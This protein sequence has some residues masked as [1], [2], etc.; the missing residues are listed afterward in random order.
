MIRQIYPGTSDEIRMSEASTDNR[1]VEYGTK[2]LEKAYHWIDRASFRRKALSLMI[3]AI[4]IY[5][6]GIAY[7]W[8]FTHAT[9]A[10]G[11]VSIFQARTQTIL[12]GEL[13]YKDVRTETPPLINYLMVPSQ[14]LG[15]ADHPWIYAA[16]ATVFVLL[17]SLMMYWWFRRYDDRKAYLV[18]LFVLLCP[19]LFSRTVVGDDDSIVAF[20]FMLG[21][22]SLL[23]E[24]PRAS[25]AAIVIGV[26]VKMW[27]ILLLPVQFLRLKSWRE[28]IETIAIGA[29]VSLLVIL[30]FL[31]LCYDEFVDFLSYYFLTKSNRTWEGFSIAHFLKQGG[32]VI[33]SELILGTVLVSLLA[34]ILYSHIKR[35]G[36]WKSATFIMIVFIVVY[37]KMHLGYY[38]MPMALLL[39]WAIDDW[40][41]LA[42]LFATYV[43]LSLASRCEPGMSGFLNDRFGN[44]WL[45]G[46][47][48]ASIGALMF[49]DVAR[50]AFKRR[51]FIDREGAMAEDRSERPAVAAEAD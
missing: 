26:W 20:F 1:F 29:L 5:G 44:A 8:T 38:I 50:R 13:L 47:V 27:A 41:I 18:G 46:L 7:A 12:D 2:L 15:G 25:A 30:P 39:V 23:F 40:K 17:L 51:S 42:E 37:P 14:A 11:D 22:V 16:Y 10:S 45:P 6:G 31:V 36:A 24:R 35:W 33:P 21:A 28:R 3:F 43:P 4:I 49:A 48:F 32:M 34:A 9:T 19:F